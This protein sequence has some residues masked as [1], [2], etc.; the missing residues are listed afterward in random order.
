M[1]VE[2]LMIADAAQVVGNKLYL[3]GGGWDVLT[4]NSGFPF[5]QHLAIA[6]SIK[7]PWGETNRKHSFELEIIGETQSSEDVKPLLKVGGQFEVGRPPGIPA[8]RDQRVQLAI[9]INLKIDSPGTRNVIAKINGQEM[10]RF[11]FLVVPGPMLALRTE[12]R[13]EE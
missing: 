8:G 11:D 7:V 6:I 3:L 10:R 5:P 9:D 4:V 1:D 13:G 12:R 2:W